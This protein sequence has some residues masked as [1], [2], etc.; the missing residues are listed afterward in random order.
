M[1]STVR[2]ITVAALSMSALGTAQAGYFKRVT[3]AGQPVRIASH[4]TWNAD[5]D[6]GPA[7]VEVVVPPEHGR[8][9]GIRRPTTITRIERGS[10]TCRGHRIE[11]EAVIYRP[12]LGFRGVDGFNY[13]STTANGTVLPHQALVDVR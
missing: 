9:V 7:K 6:G 2:I 1:T 13:T 3:A 11:A 10:G 8:L 12:A 5:C 4:A